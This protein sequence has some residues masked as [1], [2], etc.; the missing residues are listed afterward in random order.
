M[1]AHVLYAGIAHGDI[2]PSNILIERQ[3]NELNCLL[4]DF[5]SCVIRGQQRM[6]TLSPPWN[7]PELRPDQPQMCLGFDQLSRADL[8][9]L[10]LVC[11]HIM[12]PLE[13]LQAAGLSFLRGRESDEKWEQTVAR[14]EGDKLGLGDPESFGLRVVSVVEK[15]EIPPGHKQLLK[16]VAS[17]TI[18]VRSWDRKMPWDESF[19]LM[20]E[21]LSLK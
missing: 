7:A 11:L 21:H 1:F 3:G 15:A 4:I 2:K 5:G 14:L 20:D 6:P 18:L 19:R 13:D 12:L 17:G 10:G 8:F 16:A 9:S